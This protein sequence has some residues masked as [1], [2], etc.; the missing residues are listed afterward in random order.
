LVDAD[1]EQGVILDG[2]HR[3]VFPAQQAQEGGIAFVG[4]VDV[5]DGGI[6]QARRPPDASSLRKAM[7][8]IMAPSVVL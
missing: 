3:I 2:G 8:S 1:E 7:A 5:F 4:L 6:A